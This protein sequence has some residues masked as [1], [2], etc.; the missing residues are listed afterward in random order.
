[1]VVNGFISVVI[2]NI[3]KRFDLTSKQSGIIASSYNIASVICLIP[4]SYF[5]GL[6]H[7]PHWLSLGVMIMGLGSFIFALPHFLTGLYAYQS[8]GDN[9]N[10]CLDEELL[11]QMPREQCDTETHETHLSHYRYLFILSQL[12]HGAGAT[13]L[14]TLSVTYLDENL[15]A[16]SI[17]V[18]VGKSRKMLL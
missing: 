12:F 8:S 4:V 13:P 6:G 11:K 9:Y 1:M 7:K 10:S 14:C 5:G 3:E 17:P 18:Y 16:H 2:S 15:P